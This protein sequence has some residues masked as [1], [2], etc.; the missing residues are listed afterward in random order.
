MG[1]LLYV[2]NDEV[3]PLCRLTVDLVVFNSLCVLFGAMGL[4]EEDHG[5]IVPVLY[6]IHTLM[7]RG[8]R[9]IHDMVSRGGLKV[10]RSERFL[11]RL[12]KA[13]MR[14]RKNVSKI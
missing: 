14:Q 4:S 12:M 6:E 8:V 9:N 11:K 1:F 7:H 3:N 2:I 13:A 5:A 10:A